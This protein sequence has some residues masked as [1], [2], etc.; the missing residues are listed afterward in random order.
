MACATLGLLSS[1]AVN[2]PFWNWYDFPGTYTVAQLADH[3]IGF[4]LAGLV[5]AKL[6]DPAKN[7]AAP[8]A[9]TPPAA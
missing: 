1:L 9:A 5:L 4:A 6:I 8:T 3:T 2:V 7:K